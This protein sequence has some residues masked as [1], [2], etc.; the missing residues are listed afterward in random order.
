MTGN[1]LPL[2]LL[3]FTAN[4]SPASQCGA[5]CLGEAARWLRLLRRPGRNPPVARFAN[6]KIPLAQWVFRSLLL[7]PWNGQRRQP[8]PGL[9]ALYYGD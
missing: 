5:T 6:A 3:T 7:A 4:L 9:M 2:T 1:L 8:E